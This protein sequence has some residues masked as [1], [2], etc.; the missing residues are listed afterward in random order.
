[1]RWVPFL[2]G[3]SSRGFYRDVELVVGY[4]PSDQEALKRIGRFGRGAELYLR[5]GITWPARPHHRGAFSNVPKGVI[6]SHTGTMVF[7][8]PHQHWS[9]LALLNSDAYIALLHLLMPRGGEDSGQTLKYEI[10]YVRSV[11]IPTLG[12][13]VAAVLR[14]AS[15]RC[16][17]AN[18]NLDT[19]EPTSHAFVLPHI[20]GCN[21]STLAERLGAWRAFT[22][23]TEREL[24]QNQS[25]INAT[26]RQLYG[27]SEDDLADCCGNIHEA[28]PQPK[29]R[30]AEAEA[31]LEVPIDES[32]LVSTLIDSV[33]GCAF[34]R[35][36]VRYAMGQKAMPAL[37]DPFEP[38][39]V[40]PPG[41]LQNP[42]GLPAHAEEVPAA[43]PV[44]IP[45]DGI[46][47]DD[48]G[49]TV[50]LVGRM[51]EVFRAI[52]Q[53]SADAI[54]RE[55]V[56]CLSA[57]SE[58]LRHWL[59]RNF[60]EDHIKR[61]SRSRRKA[62]I[63]WCLSTPSASYSVWLYYHRFTKDMLYRALNDYLNP[64]VAHEE[65][66]LTRIRQDAGQTP[67]SRQRKE[68]DE[69][70]GFVE[71]LKNFATE[72]ARVAPL[73]KPDLNDGVIIN[74]AP[75]WRLVSL[76][77]S[78]TECKDCWDRLVVGEYDWAHL[79]MHLWPERVV[80]QCASDRSLAS[81][82]TDG[83]STNTFSILAASFRGQ[84]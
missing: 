12:A 47:V 81:I 72:L 65:T 36:D 1:M 60:F 40:C 71:E 26:A 45:W 84:S 18:R 75:L 37:P 64:K 44:R 69:Q 6:F 27:L 7:S 29:S 30:P 11:P 68:I 31:D 10:G 70:E 63:C 32:K 42:Q 48:P 38:L 43:Y 4:S 20:L 57:G 23:E 67:T 13:Q 9:L 56:D 2:K 58:D 16:W 62:P 54:Y 55:A 52:W 61:Y 59:Q 79:A 22:H 73:W 50:D 82:S 41:H 19:H 46:L 14:S 8:P 76:R 49:H 33:L 21:G 34:G 39:P 74:F 77:S 66:Q 5:E 3:G 28:E 83:N 24:C 78:Q 35:W 80:P 25:E 15:H 51:R 53:E 17:A